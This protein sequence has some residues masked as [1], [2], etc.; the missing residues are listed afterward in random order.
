MPEGSNRFTAADLKALLDRGFDADQW[1]SAT[2]EHFHVRIASRPRTLD[3]Q[4][5]IAQLG[6]L[7]ARLTRVGCDFCELWQRRQAICAETDLC[8][9]DESGSE[10]AIPC[11]VVARS[12]KSRLIDLRLYF[13]PAPFD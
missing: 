13:D 12:A 9:L 7:F 3:R 1:H 10:R 2:D 8:Y 11:V 5:S 6:S 4:S